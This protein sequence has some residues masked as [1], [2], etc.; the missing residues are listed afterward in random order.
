MYDKNY[1]SHYCIFYFI[2]LFFYS[3]ST[4]KGNTKRKRKACWHCRAHKQERYLKKKVN[5]VM[6]LS[7]SPSFKTVQVVWRWKYRIRQEWIER[8][9]LRWFG[10]IERMG[11]EGFVKKVHMSESV[12]P[13][14][15]GRPLGWWRDR[16]KEYMCERG[17][18]RGGGLDQ[19]RR[20]C[21]DRERWRF[22]A[23]ATPLGNIPR[24]SEAS[25][26]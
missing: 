11:S 14:S 26:L 19:A 2:Y 16:V 4:A 18:T 8:Y 17:A 6:Q 1:I 24:G 25:E 21:L 7:W 9:T 5:L 13:N 23:V 15:R 22:S 20:E 12:D 3:Q 10:H